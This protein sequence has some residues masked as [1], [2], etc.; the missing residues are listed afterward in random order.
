MGNK[1]AR[2]WTRVTCASA[3]VADPERRRRIEFLS[4]LLLALILLGALSLAVQALFVPGFR[5]T[6]LFLTPALAFLVVAYALNCRGRYTAAALL[7]VAVMAAGCFSALAAD[8]QDVFAFA[9]LVVPVFLARLFLSERHFLLAAGAIV[10]GISLV[11]PQLGVTTGRV[12]AG[13]I[14]VVLVA[15]ILWLAIRHRAA[16]E[17]DRRADLAAREARYRSVITTMAEGITVQLADST[18]ID[19]NPAAERIL[20]LSRD[21]IAGRTSLDPRW[22]AI[23][24]DGS[25]FPGDT[26]PSVIALRTGLAQ[27]NV[28][29]GVHHPDGRLVWIS[30][31]AEPIRSA[32]GEP[33][34]GVVCSFAD[35]TDQLRQ[36]SEL[37]ASEARWRAIFDQTYQFSGVLEPDGTVVEANWTALSFAGVELADVVGKPFWETPWWNHSP[38]QQEKL[39]AGIELAARGE[40]VRFE[41]THPAPDGTIA[42]IDFSLKPVFDERG[43]VAMLIP[44]GRDIT[45]RI[46]AESALRES[47]A[48]LM[49]AQQIA[50]FGSWELDV[51][52]G[53][54]KWSAEIYRIFELD[55]LET[56][57]DYDAFLSRIHPADRLAV[58]HL[59]AESVRK[60]EPYE[61]VH[62]LLMPDGRIKFVRESGRTHYAEDGTPL[63]SVGTVQDVTAQHAAETRVRKANRLLSTIAETN[64]MMVRESDRSR[65]M[66]E[67]CRILVERGE[68]P[69]VWIGLADWESGDLRPAASAGRADAYLGKINVRCDDTPAGRGPLG[70]AARTGE[71]VVV[72][73]TEVEPIFMPW[74]VAA[75]EM[76]FRS[77]LALPL[78]V[79]DEVI[80]TIGVYA[81]TPGAFEAE[82]TELL[83][84]LAD[85]VGHRLRTIEDALERRRAESALRESEARYRNIVETAQEGI[86]T[87]DAEG[88]TTFVNRMMAEMLGYRVEE[89]LGRSLFDFMDEEGRKISTRNI[90]RRRQGIAEQHEFR[91]LRKDGTSI[92]ALL[93]TTPLQ[94]EHGYAG[95]LAMVTDITARKLAEEALLASAAMLNKAQEVG[96][97]GSWT[98]D[99]ASNAITWSRHTYRLYG[100]DPDHPPD[101][102]WAWINGHVH[103]EDKGALQASISAAA[104]NGHASPVEFRV[105]WPDGSVHW[106]YGE[107]ELVRDEKGNAAS[108][109]GNLQDITV[110]KRAEENLLQ[111]AKGVSATTGVNF[112]ESLV[113]HLTR[114]L[115]ADFAF[116]AEVVPDH[117]DRVRT[118]VVQVGSERVADFE[119]VLK[120]TPCENVVGRETCSYPRSVQ[121][122]FPDDQMLVDMG[123]EAYVGTP[124]FARD[125][126]ALG[127]MAVL[128]RQPI[129]DDRMVRSV[130]EIF[131]A[132]AAAEWER[133][134]VEEAMRQSESNFRTLT[135]NAN[136][137]ILVNLKGRH[138]FANERA[139]KL[140]GYSAEEIK[141]TGI[142]TLVHPEDR[143]KVAA[144]F[145]DRH[146]GKQVP[147]V[148]EAV[149]LKRDGEPVPVEITATLT[150]WQGEQA[151]LI[152]V[153]DMSE[154][155]RADAALRQSEE[156]FRR[157]FEVTPVVMSVTRERDFTF[158]DLNEAFCELTGWRRDEAI[159]RTDLDL[160]MWP[161]VEERAEMIEQLLARGAFHNV[162]WRL[163]TRTGELRHILG[164]AERMRLADEPC[165]LLVGQ[166]ISERRRADEQMRKLSSALEQTAEAVMIT[167]RR[168]V[169]EYV[170]PAFEL[171]TGYTRNEVIGGKPSI[172][173]SGRQGMEFYRQLWRTISS[174]E[175]FS[176]VFVN[177]RKDGSLFYEE[178][179]ITP[180]KN[181]VGEITHYV[182]TGH[183][184]T[185]RMQTQEQLR[186]LAHHDALTE[187]PNRTLL[188][189]RLKQALA[190]VRRG[191]RRLAVLFLDIDRFKNINDT[192]GHDIGD[193]LLQ[194]MSQRLRSCLRDGD[195]VARFGGDEFVVLLDDL[196]SVTDVTGIAQ[197]IIEILK[198]PFIVGDATLHVT[199]SIGVS[200]FPNDGEDSGTLLKN[201]DTA[202]YRAKDLGRNNYQFYSAD[203]SAR[204]F[205]RLT[206]ENSLRHAL[207]REQF[208]LYYQ[209]QIDVRSGEIVG[210]EALLRWQHPEFGLVA[211]ADFVPLLEETGLIMQV[212]EWVLRRACQQ[213]RQWLDAGHTTLRVA[214]NLSSRQFNDRHLAYLVERILKETGVPPASVE[215]ELTEGLIMQQTRTT[216]DILAALNH[217][218][219]RLGLDDFGTGYSSLSYLRR[220]PL[221]TLKIDRSFVLDIPK[222]PD[223]MAI[224]QAII[225]M[226]RSLKLDLVAEGVETVEQRD[227]LLNQGCPIMQGHLFG[228]PMPVKD[229]DE[230]LSRQ[231]D[232]AR[233]RS[234]K[235]ASRGAGGGRG[236]G[237]R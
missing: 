18:I 222:D 201:A 79:G 111:I 230:M 206:L 158:V 227:F 134:R 45:E 59:Y 156:R 126:S 35:I 193:Q 144:R 22:R 33:P 178:K 218:G 148:Y 141:Q 200:L 117:A 57:V 226:G 159:G 149:F 28:V 122:L 160:D 155:K 164:S 172:V 69:M 128:Y 70:V 219:I 56:V 124:L 188:L 47:E 168:G 98:W 87:I 46:R 131:A 176:E 187:L 196:G 17:T 1:L 143:E 214:L 189:D 20:G 234:P 83:A 67:L 77:V 64:A 88:S 99:L 40:F 232:T 66:V 137:G 38:V 49:E 177:K 23:H 133:L 89:M 105:I 235:A 129:E 32:P 167:D 109:V 224:T 25:A 8:P 36:Q 182:S 15:T 147:N 208:T 7:S 95:A 11:A 198:P 170:N 191:N 179:T 127:L 139:L 65:V 100:A 145:R 154:R 84:R 113:A 228:H 217:T 14:F 211:P 31:N 120:G 104:N 150:T 194:D 181:Q 236:R 106:L 34:Q 184:I 169:V 161:N 165:I 93:N 185:E 9:Y 42:Y 60:H 107:G 74:R 166:D 215:L 52:S 86:W 146:A 225:M 43:E 186:F 116:V 152:F 6:L 183:D 212:G 142:E 163:R 135:E 55:P 223:D 237:R 220:F 125:G 78:F 231:P 203:M 210:A 71:P 138:V 132:R 171:I 118:M 10:L 173:K 97:T 68:Y 213:L 162:E 174:G 26:H 80:G 81:E 207:E 94:D 90:E 103:P 140:L 2:L 63:R 204:A 180:L 41:T 192:L 216:M 82:E 75:R 233:S 199:A 123:V 51:A 13:A 229:F 58:D 221:D 136:V 53:K 76:G 12:G 72:N 121:S 119:Y 115:S 195:T 151:G 157:V 153:Q 101:D 39:R 19:C 112:F 197:K 3:A 108:M 21:Q 85:T 114:T 48:R 175:V 209:P 205:E 190:R 202:M 24:P 110:R 92:W 73:D 5:R 96:N 102:L 30:I 37:A 4:G 29:M 27:R 54:L 50:H 61:I 16:I 62:R 91:F 44:E 130:L